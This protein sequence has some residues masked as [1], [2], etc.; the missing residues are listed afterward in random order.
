MCVKDRWPFL[1]LPSSR[2]TAVI[3]SEHCISANLSNLAPLCVQDN[4]PSV[5]VPTTDSSAEMARK[6]RLPTFVYM[7]HLMYQISVLDREIER[8]T[9]R[10]REPPSSG[11]NE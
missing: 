5:V 3:I 6:F 10:R 11:V 7:Y 2:L 8:Q 4:H 9:T 1:D